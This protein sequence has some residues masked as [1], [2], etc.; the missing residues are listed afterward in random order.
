MIK[1]EFVPVIIPLTRRKIKQIQEKEQ[2]EFQEKR[3]KIRERM[4]QEL[5]MSSN[6]EDR[7][8]AEIVAK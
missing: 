4:I 5:R 8:F 2:D 7:A 1:T 3:Q 6:P